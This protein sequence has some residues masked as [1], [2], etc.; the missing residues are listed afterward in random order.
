MGQW[1]LLLAGLLVTEQNTEPQSLSGHVTHHYPW[2]RVTVTCLSL[3]YARVRGAAR[4]LLAAA[5]RAGGGAGYGQPVRGAHRVPHLVTNQR[6]GTVIS[7]SEAST[8]HDTRV[9]ATRW[10][11]DGEGIRVLDT[12]D[13]EN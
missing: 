8:H 10:G 3:T 7:Q 5:G 13:F 2:S 6:S 12:S 1:P 11:G 4:R 9:P